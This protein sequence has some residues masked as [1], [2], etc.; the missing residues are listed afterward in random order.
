MAND[1]DYLRK[2]RD[3]YAQHRVLPSFARIGDLLG[4]SSKG[5]VAKLVGR[6]QEPGFLE[7]TKDRRL[8]PGRRF[9]ERPLAGSSVA[10]GLPSPAAE[11]M[12][13]PVTID[14]DLV[15]HPSRTVLVTVKGDSM[16]DAGILPGD[17][18]VVERRH[19]ASEGDIVVAIV[20]NEY[21]VKRLAKERGRFVLK[22]ENKAYP[23]LRPNELEI[24]GVVVGTYR[25]YR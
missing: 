20:D 3:Y 18:V 11:D 6:L 12:Q 13:D 22:P 4:F 24:F 2:L 1:S 14:Q 23:A 25:K 9:F 10:A 7:F 19:A 15:R 21:T 17:K 8:K 5:S 16:I